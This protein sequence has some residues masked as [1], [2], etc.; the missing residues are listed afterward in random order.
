[1]AKKFQLVRRQISDTHVEW[2]TT[3]DGRIR[4]GHNRG[5]P[6]IFPPLPETEIPRCILLDENVKLIWP[7]ER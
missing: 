6:D 5:V 4:E 2:V 7:G 1:M 3:V